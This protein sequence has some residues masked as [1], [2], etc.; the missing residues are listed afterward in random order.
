MT[1]VEGA[2]DAD[3]DALVALAAVA[4][5]EPWSREQLAR[6]LALA[7]AHVDVWRDGG[8]MHGFSVYWIVAGELQILAIATEPARRRRGIARALLDRALAGARDAG[9]TLATLEVRR[10]NAAAIALYERAGFRTVATRAAYYRDGE[11]ALVMHRA[12]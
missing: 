1:L 12:L 3:L 4:L 2:R 10:G 7:W 5:P 6:E 9:C 11:D 8:D